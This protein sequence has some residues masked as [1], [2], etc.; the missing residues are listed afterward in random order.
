MDG[1]SNTEA[2][3]RAEREKEHLQKQL[4]E[5]DELSR[6]LDSQEQ[7]VEG[8]ASELES[9]I[10]TLA[11]EEAQLMRRKN[12]LKDNARE[13]GDRRTEIMSER[14]KLERGR[15]ILLSAIAKVDS[16][17][18]QIQQQ[19]ALEETQKIAAIQT[20]KKPAPQSRP[21]E[22]RAHPRLAVEVE[23][24]MH[25]QHN[26]YTGL[27]ENLS[28]GGLFV[29]TYENIPIG[30]SISVT[31]RLPNQNAIKAEGTVRWVREHSDFT[32]DVSPG[33]GVQFTD[34]QPDDRRVIE[35]FIKTRA[36]L[37]YESF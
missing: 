33:I 26:F 19:L 3:A 16:R 7:L 4:S 14:K 9:R 11:K 24:S 35:S 23:V 29:A 20:E 27:T 8:Q 22:Q 1:E 15:S 10:R 6:A 21:E 30:T 13:V 32:E 17:I 5:I 31:V 18:Q 2:I 25:T 36:P 34:L 28:E 37:F 12:E